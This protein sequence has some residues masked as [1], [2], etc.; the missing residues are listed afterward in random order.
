M[1]QLNE[2][3]IP[4]R[5]PRQ[6]RR[7]HAAPA[8]PTVPPV[9]ARDPLQGSGGRWPLVRG[10]EWPSGSMGCPHRAPVG[11]PLDEVPARAGRWR[12]PGFGE[13]PAAP[14]PRSSE[15]A[16][17]A[18][19]ARPGS[20]ARPPAISSESEFC[21]ASPSPQ[22]LR[23]PRRGSRC[24]RPRCRQASWRPPTA[25]SASTGSAR[26]MAS[27]SGNGS[28]TGRSERISPRNWATAATCCFSSSRSP[29]GRPVGPAG[30]RCADREARPCRPSPT[31]RR[32]T[33]R[34][35]HIAVR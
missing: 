28:G 19:P 21:S 18:P 10:H 13:A 11:R 5:W 14:P 8:G 29:A 32:T 12:R 25:H 30:R 33:Q 34:T 3:G 26:A 35:A 22:G 6:H 20:P 1:S 15:S 4:S 23:A 9:A 2:P 16:R 7:V 31:R 17:P 27:S 24:G